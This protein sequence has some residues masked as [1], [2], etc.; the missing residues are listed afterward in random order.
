MTG[1]SLLFG[2]GVGRRRGALPMGERSETE[3][4]RR[5]LVRACHRLGELGLVQGTS[6]N[7]SVRRDGGLLITASGAPLA[8]LTEH[9]VVAMRGDGSWRGA[10]RPSTEWRLHRDLLAARPEIGAVVHTHSAYATALSCLRAPIPPFHY[11][12]A[13]AGGTDIPCAE[14]ATFGTEALSQAALRALTG[15][16]ACLL[17]NHGVVA[18]GSTLDEAVARAYEVELL[19]RQYAIVRS[20]GAPVLLDRAEMAE[21]LQRFAAYGRPPQDGRDGNTA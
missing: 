18:V 9:D 5:A 19:A 3:A 20:V 16:S 10:A 13:I 12:V 2:P 11:M 6:G 7:V 17:A 14:Y 21:V 8:E 15:R 1:H 4:L